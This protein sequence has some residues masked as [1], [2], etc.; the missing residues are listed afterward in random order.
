MPRMHSPPLHSIFIQDDSHGNVEKPPT[1]RLG[2]NL[3]VV[4]KLLLELLSIHRYF[5]NFE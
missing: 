1:S 4:P 5:P 2:Q 3:D